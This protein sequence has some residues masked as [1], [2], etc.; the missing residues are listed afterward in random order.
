MRVFQRDIYQIK[1][2]RVSGSF[3]QK[4]FHS[5]RSNSRITKNYL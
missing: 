2:S 4:T 5:W 3:I 1:R